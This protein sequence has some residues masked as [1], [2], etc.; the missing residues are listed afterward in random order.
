MN[1]GQ[2]RKK[3]SG[4]A[5]LTS[6]SSN[7]YWM[8]NVDRL[9]NE[10]NTDVAVDLGFPTRLIYLNAYSGR[11]LP[12]IQ[13]LMDGGIIEATID[14]K[15]YNARPLK[16]VTVSELQTFLPEWQGDGGGHGWPRFLLH[17]PTNPTSDTRIVPDPTG[18]MD[19]A[20]LYRVKPV[21]MAKLTD[22]P[23]GVPVASGV[24]TPA[25]LTAHNL[26]A[27][28]TAILYLEEFAVYAKDR[29][30]NTVDASASRLKMLRGK[31]AE[32][33]GTVSGLVA[34]KGIFPR[35]PF[36]R[37]HGNSSWGMKTWGNE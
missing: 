15:S 18:P 34:A 1:M 10:A 32:E 5:N 37:S 35:N 36:S 26:V 7:N 16:I 29:A 20:I 21:D 24:V 31:Y 11:N 22:L 30:I 14:Y 25:P 13:D 23:L 28:R 8:E 19:Y 9:I 33:K 6:P 17:D 4:L 12:V 2:I 27:I 3:A